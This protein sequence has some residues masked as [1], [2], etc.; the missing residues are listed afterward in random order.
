[1][2]FCG[3][4]ELIREKEGTLYSLITG[5]LFCFKMVIEFTH[6]C[7]QGNLFEFLGIQKVEVWDPLT[8]EYIEKNS[9]NFDPVMFFEAT[10]SECPAKERSPVL[11]RR[12]ITCLQIL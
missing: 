8:E 1:M 6:F 2:N 12:L 11:N 5:I 4:F 10:A 3:K 9:K 7:H